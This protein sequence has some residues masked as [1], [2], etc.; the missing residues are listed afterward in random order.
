MFRA[1]LWQ[2]V[3]FESF[4]EF[5]RLREL[6]KHLLDL[7]RLT[8]VEAD[9]DHTSLCTLLENAFAILAIDLGICFAFHVES[10][11]LMKNW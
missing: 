1:H 7:V 3:R 2:R 11:E 10:E 9:W 4:S 5:L 8:E 6:F